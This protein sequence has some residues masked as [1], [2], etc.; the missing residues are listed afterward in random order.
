MLALAAGVVPLVK[1]LLL[2]EWVAS[3]DLTGTLWFVGVLAFLV[4]LATLGWSDL[5]ARDVAVLGE[6]GKANLW[7]NS[8]LILAL[9][10]LG[11]IILNIFFYVIDVDLSKSIAVSLNLIAIV[12][13]QH[14]IKITRSLGRLFAFFLLINVKNIL[15]IVVLGGFVGF[16][17]RVGA[18][19]VFSIEAT[20][21]LGVVFIYCIRFLKSFRSAPIGEAVAYSQETWRRAFEFLLAATAAGVLVQWDRIIYVNLM[22]GS[23]YQT[24]V[25]VSINKMALMS[26]GALGYSFLYTHFAEAFRAGDALVKALIWRLAGMAGLA[27]CFLLPLQVVGFNFAT[28]FLAIGPAAEASA[29]ALAT[30]LGW[31]HAAQ[32]LEV[33]FQLS[34]RPRYVVFASFFSF[35]FFNALCFS[36]YAVDGLSVQSALL[37]AILARVMQIAA[38]L[39]YLPRVL[40]NVE[41]SDHA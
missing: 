40:K 36:L 13:F 6:K 8:T 39:V 29:I 18:E 7:S 38:M 2:F 35:V 9:V 17:G 25:F 34:A 32:I 24:Y 16:Y 5:A 15:D 19:A 30:L 21:T 14:V 4:P 31:L 41:S 20:V 28:K 26:I 22:P 27:V 12:I 10:V 1:Q 11:A 37:I 33:V 3:E 23:A